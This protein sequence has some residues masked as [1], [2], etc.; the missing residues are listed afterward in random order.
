VVIRHCTFV[1]GLAPLDLFNLQGWLSIEN[2]IL[3]RVQVNRDEVTG[4][5]MLISISDS[6]LDGVSAK[7]GESAE[8]M[9][10]DAPNEMRAHAVLTVVRST[11][12][13]AVKAHAMDL[14]EDSIFFGLVD[15]SRSQRGC[16]RFC[17][18]PPGSLTPRRFCCQPD[19]AVDVA[20]AKLMA[21]LKD[22]TQDQDAE[23]GADAAKAVREQAANRTR[24]QFESTHYGTPGYCRLV[25][26]LSE[27][28]RRGA[29]DESEMGALHDLYQPQREANLRVR[30]QEYTPATMEAGIIYGDHQL[31]RRP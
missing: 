13:G 26:S 27:E 23:P 24:P 19:L 3:G 6:I 21:D 16:M 2:S 15:V 1:P 8:A 29:E 30:L 25:S 11:V 7:K 4:D 9:A 20:L 18:V 17:Y 10:V 22:S 14:G 31:R 5:P 12:L 28:I